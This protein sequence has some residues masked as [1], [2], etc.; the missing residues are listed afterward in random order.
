[1]AVIYLR[2]T[3][4]SDSDDGSTWALAKAT[5]A[6]ALTAAGAG[7]TVY[8]SQSHAETQAS[9]MTLA[10]PGTV[11]APVL[12]LCVNDGAA[13]PT[14]LVTT[15]TV[16]TTGANSITC[17]GFAYVYGVS[18]QAGSSTSS[19]SITFGA[20]GVNWGWMIDSGAL[21]LLGSGSSS[22]I[23]AGMVS[24]KCGLLSLVN[25]PITFSNSTS[26]IYVLQ[27]LEWTNTSSAINGTTPST[28]FL[29]TS[30]SAAGIFVQCR[31]VD[32]SALAS[33]CYL[34]TPV[35][36]PG[37]YRFIE[38]KL[39]ASVAPLSTAIQSVGGNQVYI[40]NCD[41]SDTNYRMEHYKYQGSTK[42]ETSKVRSGGASDGTTAISWNM[43]TLAGA[44][45][46][47]P[48]ESPPI[49]IWNDTTG[50]V[51]T[52]T[53]EVAQDNAATALND[54]EIWLEVEY[55]GTSGYPLATTANDRK[56]TILATATAQT[57][58]SATWNNMT[59]PTKQKLEVTFT[60]QAKGYFQARVMLAKPSVTVYVDPLLVVT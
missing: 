2:S 29:A 36:Y 6:A 18:I 32:L 8:V 31:G 22:K 1:M 33:G 13:P 44:T 14:A 46:V 25:T 51:K 7:G 21:K 58:S 57:S 10:S 3:D 12:V 16:S 15:A 42:A 45:F 26:G 20:N 53:I 60:P 41:S 5:L 24:I 34:V 48:L 54:D 28:L 59:S 52:V 27:R 55:L 47:S 43:T 37:E 49:S 9:A 50:A 17:N 23:Y 19:A 35:Q 4:G 11:A 39:G 56:A 30:A 40:D 38:C